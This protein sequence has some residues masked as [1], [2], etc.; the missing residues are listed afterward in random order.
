MSYEL[1]R[2]MHFDLTSSIEYTR[3]KFDAWLTAV[4]TEKRG[5][6]DCEDYAIYWIDHLQKLGFPCWMELVHTKNGNHA[7]C[8]VEIECRRYGFCGPREPVKYVLDNAK[9]KPVK[10][11]GYD[12]YETLTWEQVQERYSSW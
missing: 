2:K 5:K 4:E 1:L 12:T 11:R 9:R 6:G 8:V 7:I 10:Y 3:D